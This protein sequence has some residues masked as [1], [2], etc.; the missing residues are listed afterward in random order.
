M[1][2]T[3]NCKAIEVIN[4]NFGLHRVIW[5]KHV[6]EINELTAKEALELMQNVLK[7]GKY[8]KAKYN[9]DKLNIASFGNQTPH[10]HIHVCPRWKT[11]PWWPNT[12]WSQTNKSIW[13]L[14]NKENGLNIGSGVLADLDKI[15]FPVRK[16]VFI[17][18]QGIS[19]SDEWDQFDCIS[20]HVGL[21]NHQPVGTGRLG[22]DGRI[23]RLSVIKNQRGLGYGRIILN[24]LEKIAISLNFKQVYVHS[25]SEAQIFYE[26][27]GYVEAGGEFVECRKPHQNDQNFLIQK[28][29]FAFSNRS[30]IAFQSS[31]F[32]GSS[33]RIR[34]NCSRSR[35]FNLEYN[36]RPY[37]IARRSY[38]Y[39]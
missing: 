4:E 21:V 23:G 31:F 20:Q 11:D 7:L 27:A 37:S 22:P 15:A 29:F 32:G 5:N 33:K 19:S 17:D 26:K 38:F 25:Q 24:E 39:D 6:K 35:E 36:F 2:N 16:S 28:R 13:K 12:I 14:A 10:I 1:W 34:V 3:K 9:P 8:V 18:E 30:D